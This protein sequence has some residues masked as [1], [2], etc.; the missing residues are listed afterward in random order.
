M[1]SQIVDML[2]AVQRPSSVQTVQRR[3][4]HARD[5]VRALR[6]KVRNLKTEL[7][8]QAM[9]TPYGKGRLAKWRKEHALATA[10]AARLE[11]TTIRMAHELAWYRER[12]AMIVRTADGHLADTGCFGGT[13]AGLDGARLLAQ[14][15][16]D[17]PLYPPAP[18][19]S[20]AGDAGEG[21]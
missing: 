11:A 20:G 7:Q 14:A 3:D 16:L 18:G 1:S 12:L 9:G 5:M 10:K 6:G 21:G 13:A 4:K 15:A 2:L 19:A 17:H 8:R